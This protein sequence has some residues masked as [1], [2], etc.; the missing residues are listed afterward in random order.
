MHKEA[1][2]RYAAEKATADLKLDFERQ[3]KEL[4]EVKKAH[5]SVEAS[6]KNAEKQAEELRVKLRQSEEKLTAE[7]QA[8]STLKAELARTKEEARLAREATE[9]A[10]A[11][12][13]KRAVRDTEAR[14]TE[15]VAIVCREYITMSWGVALDRAD[16]PAD[17]DLRKAKN[18]FFPED[19]REIPDEDAS[20]EP[21][22]TDSSILEA[23]GNEQ[24]VQDKPP[25]DSLSINEI[26]AQAKE[27]A[28]GTQ[29]ADD[30]PNPAQGP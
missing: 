24:T 27:V 8:V 13:Y 29:V 30:Q 16:V 7:Q 12:S 6:V 26:A 22:P 17:S 1:Q 25:E 3:D 20:K 11:A 19:V 4:K 9:K 10:V 2:S 18:I 14:I 28:P 15:E 5:A 23:G 21:F